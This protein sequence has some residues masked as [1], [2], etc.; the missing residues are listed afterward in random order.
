[1]AHGREIQLPPPRADLLQIATLMRNLI[2]LYIQ[3]G[4]GHERCPV[5]FN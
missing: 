3:K 5:Y 2:N 1:M 4:E